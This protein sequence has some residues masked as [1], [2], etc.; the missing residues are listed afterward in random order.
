MTRLLV[1]TVD[2]GNK[3]E[4]EN[5]TD[6]VTN[7]LMRPMTMPKCTNMWSTPNKR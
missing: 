5:Q 6:A 3:D 1:V 4:K 2:R 7:D